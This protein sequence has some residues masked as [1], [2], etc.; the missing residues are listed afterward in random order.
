MCNA[1]LR[2]KVDV[3]ALIMSILTNAI[4]HWSTK[5]DALA[6]VHVVG[7]MASNQFT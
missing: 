7:S 1:N 6:G 5:K 3:S 2:I 4:P